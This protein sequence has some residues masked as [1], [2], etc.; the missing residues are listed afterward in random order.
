MDANNK[1]V[2]VEMSGEIDNL[3][4]SVFC[5]L[6]TR[7]CRDVY[8]DAGHVTMA[9]STAKQAITS[10]IASEKEKAQL[11]TLELIAS[12]ERLGQLVYNSISER[13]FTTNDSE[14]GN[15]L[16]YIEN[17]ELVKLVDDYVKTLKFDQ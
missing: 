2:G 16:F 12:G 9:K 3:L 14:I 6:S 17:D 4:D 8:I 11:E 5:Q 7:A 13:Y 1:S 10:L 15:K